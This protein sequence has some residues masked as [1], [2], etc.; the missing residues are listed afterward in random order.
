MGYKSKLPG[1]NN[2]RLMEQNN[3]ITWD[4]V[5]RKYG[6]MMYG[7][8]LTMAGD[9]N[10]AAKILQESFLGLKN[11]K[12][13]SRNH[14]LLCQNLLRCAYTTTLQHLAAKR[15]APSTTQP[16]GENYPLINLLYFD[17]VSVKDAALKLNRTE[18]DIFLGIRL[19]FKQFRTDV[20]IKTGFY[21]RTVT[22][23]F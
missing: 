15:L 23:S 22:P 9:E 7:L 6:S 11:K 17:L 3:A 16:F 8:I 19:E 18:Q 5:Y 13:V 14:T 21:K 10:L 4:Q 1:R 20:R 12:I 2:K